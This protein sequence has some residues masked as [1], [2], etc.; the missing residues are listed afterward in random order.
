M[1]FLRDRPD[2]SEQARGLYGLRL[3]LDSMRWTPLDLMSDPHG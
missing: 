3:H 2:K 1:G